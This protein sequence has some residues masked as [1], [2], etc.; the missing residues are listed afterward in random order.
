MEAILGWNVLSFG[1]ACFSLTTMKRTDS[2]WLRVIDLTFRPLKHGKSVAF[3]VIWR[4]VKVKHWSANKKSFNFFSQNTSCCLLV[5]RMWSNSRISF[6][7]LCFLTVIYSSCWSMFQ[8]LI[9]RHLWGVWI[10]CIIFKKQEYFVKDLYFH[11]LY[12]PLNSIVKL[13][14]SSSMNF[15]TNKMSFDVSEN[16]IKIEQKKNQ[17]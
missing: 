14:I 13:K 8:K 17:M 3:F 16:C 15:L 4:R 11:I 5:I 9:H 12:A 7:C 10:W 1:G 6:F 2:D